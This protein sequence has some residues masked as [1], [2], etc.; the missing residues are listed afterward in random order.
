MIGHFARQRGA[1]PVQLFDAESGVDPGVFAAL[2]D[3][4]FF[5][6]TAFSLDAA[7]Q[8]AG[9]ARL[10]PQSVVMVTGGFKG[11]RVR[12]DS[13]A[14]Y[15][16]IGER[17]GSPRVVGEYGMT[18]LCSQLWTEAVPAGAV[19]GAFI[20]PPWLHVYTVDAITAAPV[21][22]EGILRFVD[23]ANTDSVVAIETMDLGVVERR[24]DGDRVT[25]KGRA[26]GS[27][28]RGCSLRAEDLLHAAR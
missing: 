1:E 26:A 13:E 27:E 16:A 18:E 9:A 12:L 19:P 4:C 15:A 14:L 22:G 17:L 6:T 7:L 11:R 25:L 23:L 2:N 3:P 21:D 20:A 8:Q 28:L 10:D 5:A 24:P